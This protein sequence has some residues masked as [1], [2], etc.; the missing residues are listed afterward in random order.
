MSQGLLVRKSCVLVRVVSEKVVWH[1][2]CADFAIWKYL[3][4]GG[5]NNLK[6]RKKA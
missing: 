4:F 5:T 1:G 2:I 3:I 6:R